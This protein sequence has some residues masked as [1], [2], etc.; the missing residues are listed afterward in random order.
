M[1]IVP[2][3]PRCPCAKAR[4]SGQRPRF[5]GAYDPDAGYAGILFAFVVGIDPGVI[6]AVLQVLLSGIR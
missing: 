6:S 4:I 1:I 3:A 5:P 2:G